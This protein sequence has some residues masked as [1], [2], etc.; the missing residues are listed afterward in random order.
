MTS[1]DYDFKDLSPYDFEALIRDLLSVHEKI[2]FSTYRIGPD[3]GIDLQAQEAEFLH[4]AQCKHT[5]DATRAKLKATAAKERD[6]LSMLGR[7]I[8]RYLFIT[9]ADIT[10]A[11]ERELRKE[12]AGCAE[13]VE[14]HGAGWLNTLLAMHPQMER[15]HFKL[16]LK[17]SVAIKEMLTGGVFLRGESRARRIEENYL[18]FVHHEVCEVAE[19][20]LESTGVSLLVGAPGAGKTA[21]AEYLVLQ[22]WR[23]GFR[24]IVDPRTVDSW[25]EWLEDDIPTIFFFDDAWG[26]T[27]LHDHAM[28][29][30]EKDFAE[31]LT[32]ILEKNARREEGADRDKVAV[33][34]SRSLILHDTR[35]YSDATRILL[36]RIPHSVI[37]VERLTAEVKSRILFNHVNV[38]IADER[39]RKQLASRDWWTSVVSHQN[40]APRIVDLVTARNHFTSGDQLI[41][42]I[43]DALDDPQQIWQS[44]FEAFSPLEQLLLLILAVSDS[45][46]VRRDVVA[47]RLHDHSA[48]AVGNAVKRLAGTWIE[49]SRVNGS[50][51]FTLSDPSQR[52]FLVRYIRREPLACLDII[53]HSSSF[54]DVR[55]LCEQGRPPELEYQPSLFA[56][57][58]TSLR[59]SLDECTVPVIKALRSYWGEQKLGPYGLPKAVLAFPIGSFIEIFSTYTELIVF[60]A[61]RYASAGFLSFATDGWAEAAQARI[62][63]L[64]EETDVVSYS[65]SIDAIEQLF[66]TYFR[67]TRYRVFE[68]PYARH[69]AWLRETI[70]RI[71]HTWDTV[72]VEALGEGQYWLDLAEAVIEHTELFE[73]LGFHE[74]AASVFDFESLDG[75]LS[76]RIETEPY[77]DDWMEKVEEIEGL[78][79]STLTESRETLKVLGLLPEK[80]LFIPD[81]EL[82]LPSGASVSERVGP[83]M[84]TGTNEAL[85]RSLG[86]PFRR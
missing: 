19:K 9:S 70:L 27:R 75:E 62:L 11:T 39:V 40:Y 4:I 20:S 6:K 43:H 83:E 52:D 32:S 7:Q 34:T 1:P 64:L 29:H 51:M 41:R 33:I 54:D 81:D 5:P 63:E 77:G 57:E 37:P 30:H 10:P 73:K 66:Y 47:S 65:E 23:R 69:V 31:F 3:G 79:E 58:E 80:D 55:S 12:F 28:S 60:H 76:F 84:S 25:W 18:R 46:G 71:W 86:D 38:A 67:L 74:G 2:A 61:D 15:R 53:N 45:Q 35:R 49:R 85:F 14:V 13:R 48:S 24:V 82:P 68:G 56:M 50:D 21:V 36:E 8:H 78:F 22:W 16:W 17:A 42:E 72:A 59:E 44:S 26:Q